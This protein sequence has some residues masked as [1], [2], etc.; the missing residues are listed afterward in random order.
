[1]IDDKLCNFYNKANVSNFDDIGF[2]CLT[3][4]SV[5]ILSNVTSSTIFTRMEPCS[6]LDLT[7]N[8]RIAPLTTQS[9][10]FLK[11]T[12][13]NAVVSFSNKSV[14]FRHSISRNL[15]RQLDELHPNSKIIE[16]QISEQNPRSKRLNIHSYSKHEWIPKWI[17]LIQMIINRIGKMGNFPLFKLF[18][19]IWR[20]RFDKKVR[21]NSTKLILTVP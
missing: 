9:K 19:E 17:W 7:S 18:K 1:M 16:L 2:P 13:P 15:K 6:G 10:L 11:S 3:L 5:R 12:K 14:H 8:F 20:S 21:S 4:S